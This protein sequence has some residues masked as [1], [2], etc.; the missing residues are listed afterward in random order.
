MTRP[1]SRPSLP[2]PPDLPPLTSRRAAR[3][4][5]DETGAAT[6]EYAIATMAA[7]AFAG[8]LVVIMRAG[9]TNRHWVYQR[10]G[11]R[12]LHCM[13]IWEFVIASIVLGAIGLA[14]LYLVIKAAVRNAFIEDRAFQAKVQ[15][16]RADQART[17]AG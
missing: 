15:K 2:V 10:R 7:V 6:A 4:F 16:Q 17:P 3:L 13:G 9:L 14:V 1:A 11:A 8:L 5:D 12:Y